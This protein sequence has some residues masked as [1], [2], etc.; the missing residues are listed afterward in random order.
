[1][2]FPSSFALV[3]TSAVALF[4]G[5]SPVAA[6]PFGPSAYVQA[7]DSPFAA[8]NF[9][10]GYFFNETF[11]DHLLNTLGLSGSPGGVTSVVF[12]PTFHD[13]VDAD[14][15]TIDGASLLG[16]SWFNSGGTTAFSFNAGV[17][18]SLPTYAGAVW[19]DGPF[20]TGVTFTAF[21]ADNATVVCTIVA[22]N[23]GNNSFS[24]ET[25]EDRFFGC[26]DA[27]GIARIQFVNSGGG[28]IEIDHVQ[29][30]RTGVNV[31]EPAAAALLGLG[32]TVAALS[33][34]RARRA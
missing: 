16:D 26:S 21:G 6:A 20:G 19:T 30:G 1:M 9:A 27:G 28:G 24:G 2:R 4:V 7:S 17:L 14:D 34:R 33:R 3:A 18:G 8:I 15:G 23:V 29:Y 12:G 25:A 32:L 5:V 13:S 31:P 10:G 22:P 11:E